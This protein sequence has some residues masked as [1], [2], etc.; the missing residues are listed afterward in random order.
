MSD[1]C[2]LFNGCPGR[3]AVCWSR[4]PDGDECPIYRWFKKQIINDACGKWISVKD[5]LPE[6]EGEYIAFDGE[7]V[8]G[9]YYE[10][11]TSG[12]RWTDPVEMY[13]EFE[14]THWMPLPEPPNDDKE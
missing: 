4:Q 7:S 9:A 11:D 1:T 12:T 3:T 10:I 6:K 5:K 14:V 8:F 2:F 13:G